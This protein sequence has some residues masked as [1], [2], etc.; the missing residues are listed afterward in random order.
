M[1]WYPADDRITFGD[2]G[3]T[4]FG[5]NQISLHLMRHSS[6]LLCQDYQGPEHHSNKNIRISLPVEAFCSQMLLKDQL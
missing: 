4:E 2:H 6:V 3:S 5:D 1:L